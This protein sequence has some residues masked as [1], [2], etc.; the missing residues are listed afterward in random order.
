MKKKTSSMPEQ[1]NSS[2]LF[3]FMRIIGSIEHPTLKISVFKMDNRLSVKFENGLYEQTFKLGA[4]ERLSTVEAVA[5]WADPALLADI[6]SNFQRM[7]QARMAA[8]E[9]SFPA[10]A[11]AVFEE[12][13]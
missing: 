1:L 2:T 11:E 9:R 7:H 10:S 6:Q 13:I 3:I 5:Q 4:D 8:F 12:I